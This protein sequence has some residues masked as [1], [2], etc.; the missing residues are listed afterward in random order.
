MRYLTTFLL[1]FTFLANASEE[2]KPQNTPFLTLIDH[3]LKCCDAEDYAEAKS[4]F[5]KAKAIALDIED[6]QLR[7]SC[8]VYLYNCSMYSGNFEELQN[9]SF[10]IYYLVNRK[11]KRP[12][13]KT[14]LELFSSVA[15][16]AT[17]STTLS[18]RTPTKGKSI[19][20][21]QT[22]TTKELETLSL[23]GLV[24]L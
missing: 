22:N 13:K 4:S 17:A 18:T 11:V 2:E 24:I 5:K 23:K 3:A 12:G 8:L 21:R 9:I 7:L 14:S 19:L 15:S 1:I 6:D 20:G 16:I 10:E